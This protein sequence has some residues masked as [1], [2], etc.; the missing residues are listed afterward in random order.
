MDDLTKSI[1][2]EVE[3]TPD[4]VN[5]GYG[6]TAEVSGDDKNYATGFGLIVTVCAVA[7]LF[8]GDMFVW[9][10][11]SIDGESTTPN[12]NGVDFKFIMSLDF[13]IEENEMEIEFEAW[14][15]EDSSKEDITEG[16]LDDTN[17]TKYT[18]DDCE[19]DETKA[20]FTNL[21][22]MVYG[23]LICGVLLAYLG[24]NKMENT[25]ALAAVGAL[26]SVGM[27]VY[28]FTVLPTAFEDDWKEDSVDDEGFFEA[29]DEDPAFFM[30][31]GK[32]EYDTDFETDVKFYN[33]AMPGIA[34]F[35]PVITLTLCGYLIIYNRD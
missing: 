33:K 12:D 14:D 2:D 11:V 32:E 7:L 10:T 8:G 19:C 6:K 15:S 20:F 30:N 23:L 5:Y 28:T 1:L 18:D 3:N 13:G 34:Y 27:L 22:Y 9:W 26:I 25:N 16:E 17:S 35:I 29:I 24:K 21:K 31:V 4:K